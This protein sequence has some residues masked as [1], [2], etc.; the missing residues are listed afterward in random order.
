MQQNNQNYEDTEIDLGQYV[1][2]MVKRKKA[3]IAVFLLTFAAGI[4]CFLFSPEIY[5]VSMMIQPPVIGPSLTGAND[6]EPAENLKSLIINGVYNEELKKILNIDLDNNRLNFKVVIPAKTNILQVSIDLEKNKKESGIALLRNLADLISVSFTKGTK[7]KT[8]DIAYQIKS[9][10]RAIL[11]A[12]ER[13]GNLRDQVKEIAAREDKLR[14][15]IKAVSINTAQILENREKLKENSVTESAATLFLASYIQNNSN[16]LNQLNNQ[17][18]ELLVRKIN[19]D[20]EVKNVNA[21]I[22]NFESEIDKLNMSQ[23]FISNTRIIV[24]PRV[25]SDPVSPSKKKILAIS[26]VMGLFL[27][28]L[29]IFAQEFWMSNSGKK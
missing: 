13:A 11:N 21:Q 27:G 24:Q 6:L 12:K 19:L 1:K 9:N 22:I 26:I 15:E 14:E 29:A 16:Y 8:D 18:S 5:R 10:E 17:L 28:V 7:A 25:L 23:G 4:A 3:F 2:V 20:F